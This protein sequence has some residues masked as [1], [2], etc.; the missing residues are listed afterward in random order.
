MY[1]NRW[2][3]QEAQEVQKNFRQ[4]AIDKGEEVAIQS[5][6]ALFTPENIV[7]FAYIM[8]PDWFYREFKEVH[9][10][11][12]EAIQIGVK[13][14]KNVAIMAYRGHGKTAITLIL[15]TVYE[16]CMGTYRYVVINSYSD[17]DSID[18]LKQIK[19]EFEEND[20]IRAV[21]GEP[22][23]EK[24]Y[25]NMS[26]ITVFGR[27]R[28]R[29]KSTGQ[30]PRGLV[31]R[32]T[33]PDRIVSDDILSDSDVLSPE[34]RQKALEWYKKA[35]MPSLSPDGH[36]E[37]INT[38]MHDE[39]VIMTIMSGATPF[40]NWEKIQLDGMAN[41]E[42]VDP[43]WK[44]TEELKE[45]QKDE[46][47]FSQ[48]I[49]NAPVKVNSGIV[50]PHMV[51][52]Y[53]ERPPIIPTFFIHADITHTAKQTSDY[54]ALGRMCRTDDNRFL[55]MEDYILEKVDPEQQARLTIEMYLRAIQDG[56]VVSITYDEKGH[57]SFG[58][59]V[60]KLARDEYDVS[61]PITPLKYPSDKVTHFTP[62]LPHFVSGRVLLP[63]HSPYKRT[64]HEQLTAFPHP[65][66]HDDF[67]DM[68]SGCLDGLVAPA[69]GGEVKVTSLW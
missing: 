22:I 54:F 36:M 7:L 31:E 32:G 37:I 38:P 8:L 19:K 3:L 34:L 14:K 58:L 67:V 24:E 21:F 43:D 35:L 6:K 5:L 45:L 47:T 63:E 53:A 65:K 62:H 4:M 13:R 48:E 12:L 27:T 18:K 49:M 51:Q 39:D 29:T 64:A 59:W 60:T 23:G 9:Y 69:S 33:R 10:R 20:R 44:S 42:T 66:V 26:D 11:H 56:Q 57:H 61:L 41:G 16:T 68:L 17:T 25:W 28:I 55:L 46:F 1:I 40:E 50:K 2:T 30:S 15:R 52:Y